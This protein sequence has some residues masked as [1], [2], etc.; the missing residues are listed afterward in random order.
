MLVLDEITL[1]DTRSTIG[2]WCVALRKNQRISQIDLARELGLSHKTIAN[3]ENGNNFTIGTLLKVLK[4]FGMQDQLH[5]FVV[6]Q[7]KRQIE[8]N[9]VNFY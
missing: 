3:L 2:K 5:L 7:L 9:E 4:H 6:E 1:K 8:S